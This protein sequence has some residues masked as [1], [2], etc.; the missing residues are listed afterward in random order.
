[1]NFL[2]NY[3]YFRS[4]FNSQKEKIWVLVDF[5]Y[6]VIN[7]YSSMRSPTSFEGLNR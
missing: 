4:D 1:M 2:I 6:G 7:N 3:S 5:F